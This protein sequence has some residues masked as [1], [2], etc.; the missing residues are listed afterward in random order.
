MEGGLIVLSYG[1]LF[2]FVFPLVAPLLASAPYL[3]LL[4]VCVSQFPP[5]FSLSRLF[6]DIS[7]HH[8]LHQ[9]AFVFSTHIS[10]DKI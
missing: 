10:L 5:L 1:S 3:L 9:P 6:G 4:A 7:S 2:F 8:P